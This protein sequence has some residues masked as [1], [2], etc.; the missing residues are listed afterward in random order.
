VG[1]RLRE[2][3]K[4]KSTHGIDFARWE[5]FGCTITFSGHEVA[6]SSGDVKEPKTGECMACGHKISLKKM[7]GEQ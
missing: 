7:R 6:E 2:C 4:C 3:P 1:E 5:R